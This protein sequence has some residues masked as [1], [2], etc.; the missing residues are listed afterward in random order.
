[1]VLIYKGGLSIRWYLSIRWPSRH[2]K[3]CVANLPTNLPTC[4]R[5]L[6]ANPI[7]LGGPGMIVH[8]G[9][10]FLCAQ[11]FHIIGEWFTLLLT[12]WQ[13]YQPQSG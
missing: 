1:M 8:L 3:Y 7:H 11:L 2:I 10:Y 5:Q 9:K 12:E 6:L 13:A 4:Y